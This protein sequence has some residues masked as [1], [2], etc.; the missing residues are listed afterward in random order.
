M[1]AKLCAAGRDFHGDPPWAVPCNNLATQVLL[2]ENREGELDRT[3]LCDFHLEA[4]RHLT[5]VRDAF[6]RRP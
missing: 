2:V 6:L 5:I 4:L 1:L 3:A